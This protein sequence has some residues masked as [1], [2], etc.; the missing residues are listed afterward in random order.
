MAAWWQVLS[1]PQ[2]LDKIL[3]Q[4]AVLQVRQDSMQAQL[5]RIEQALYAL[6]L[7]VPAGTV[8]IH[9]TG[10]MIM[11]DVQ[12]LIFDVTL[13]PPAAPDVVTRK[14]TVEINGESSTLT[15]DA[16]ATTVTGLKGLQDAVVT[17]TLVDV[18][19]AGLESPPSTK[20]VTLV[21]TIAPPAPGELGITVSGEEFESV[22]DA[23]SV[24]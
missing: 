1:T 10:E 24:S 2:K 16:E 6:M 5:D 11:A 17:V 20:T 18:D 23:D 22:A 15:L 14:V 8:Q 19:D 13:P 12:T 4:L 7:R 3:T 9:T 21:D